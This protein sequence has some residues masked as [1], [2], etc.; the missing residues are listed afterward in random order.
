M[1]ACADGAALLGAFGEEES[2]AAARA[3][4]EKTFRKND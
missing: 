3:C 2:R 1:T 4:M